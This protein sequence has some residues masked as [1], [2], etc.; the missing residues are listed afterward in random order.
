MVKCNEV[1]LFLRI[2]AIRFATL[3]FPEVK[4]S[5]NFDGMPGGNGGGYWEGKTEGGSVAEPALHGNLTAEQ[6]DQPAHQGQAQAGPLV[7]RGIEA[8]ENI[9]QPLGFDAPARVA[10]GELHPVFL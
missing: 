2:A 5:T 6:F 10:H 7:M 9:G 4:C 3:P 1:R 8:A